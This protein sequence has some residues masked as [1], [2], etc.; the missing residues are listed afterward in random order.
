MNHDSEPTTERFT[1][2]TLLQLGATTGLATVA[3]CLGGGDDGDTADDP[4]STPA[5]ETTPTATPTP[6]Q[7]AEE[8]PESSSD[9]SPTDGED[10]L[11]TDL[12]IA[13]DIDRELAVLDEP[14]VSFMEDREVEAGTLA[15]VREGEISVRR[16]YGWADSEGTESL[17]PE[18]RFR[19]GSLSKRFTD[20][21]ILRLVDAGSLALDDEV[22]PL[23]DVEA[24][25]GEP[26]DDRL[27]EITV[28]HLLNHAGGWNRLEHANPLFDPLVVV[29][30]LG[31]DRPPERDDF[32]RYMLD[33]PLQFDPGTD[34]VYSNL[35]YIVLS[36]AVEAVTG[37]TYQSFLERELFDPAGVEIELGRT[38][39][40]NRPE[41]E[42]WYDDT[43]RCS[44]LYGE[45]DEDVACAD[46]GLVVDAFSGAGGHVA[47]AQALARALDELQ[48]FWV[49]GEAYDSVEKLF[50]LYDFPTLPWFG[51]LPGSFSYAGLRPDGWVVALFNRRSLPIES[52]YEIASLLDDAFERAGE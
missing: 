17:S 11:E 39:P 13:G 30:E 45:A 25:S 33:Q 26:A 29:E 2:R 49:E 50:E 9:S 14:V 38:Q 1:R 16:R 8:T 18:T 44:N 12:P 5:D 36:L 42:V 7:T 15:M 40:E 10:E 37:T 43:E 41:D 35:G 34:S 21:V 28:E 46:Y 6:E 23:L 27:R 22:Y 52:W 32:V 19:I 20:D 51:S 4:L 31:L 48:W 3:G 24:P 47:S